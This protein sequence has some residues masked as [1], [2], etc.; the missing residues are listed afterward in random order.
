MRKRTRRK[1]TQSPV[2]RA[3]CRDATGRFTPKKTQGARGRRLFKTTEQRNRR[4]AR[5]RS[6]EMYAP[7]RFFVRMENLAGKIS[8]ASLT[9]LTKAAAETA[10]STAIGKHDTSALTDERRTLGRRLVS[11]KL[12][13]LLDKTT[14]VRLD[15]RCQDGRVRDIVVIRN[16][17]L[18]PPIRQQFH[19]DGWPSFLL[20]VEPSGAHL[21]L[22]AREDDGRDL[23]ALRVHIPQ[24]HLFSYNCFHA[25]AA[26]KHGVTANRV[27][28]YLDGVFS[29]ERDFGARTLERM[30]ADEQTRLM[31]GGRACTEETLLQVLP[32]RSE[33]EAQ[34]GGCGGG[35][36]A[37]LEW[38]LF[39]GKGEMIGEIDDGWDEDD[40]L[41]VEPSPLASI[42][43]QCARGGLRARRGLCAR[44][45]CARGL[46]ACVGV[47]AMWVSFR[48]CW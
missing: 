13:G 10:C 8:K 14:R 42:D 22:L 17:P 39:G 4:S 46:C 34:C 48:L 33:V 40:E 18:A 38:S 12:T 19:L 44:G 45:L 41:F 35:V 15:A 2:P 3:V 31:P 23:V 21:L 43:D 27:H 32:T 20:P 5:S 7:A 47:G 26:G 9:K 28:G 25:G 16:D 11:D 24:Y 36:A 1:K 37:V 6:A 29:D 30:L